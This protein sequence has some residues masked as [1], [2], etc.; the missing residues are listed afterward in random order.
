MNEDG[1]RVTKIDWMAAIPS[2]RLLEAISLSISPRVLLPVLLLLASGVLLVPGRSL[3]DM[4]DMNPVHNGINTPELELPANSINESLLV[5]LYSRRSLSS[6]KLAK[7][8]LWMLIA[9]FCG[10][11]AIRTGGCRFSTGTGPGII[12]SARHSLQSW[13]S[14]LVSTFLCGILLALF[15]V[16][17]RVLCWAGDLTHIGIT[18]AASMFY[19]IVCLVLGIGW[20]LSLAAI[21]IDRCDGAE[22]LSR[23]IC[24]VLSRWQRV[25]VYAAVCCL[26]L[27]LSNS[28]MSWLTG[29]AYSLAS[30]M[31]M[32]SD[33]LTGADTLASLRQSLEFFR[34]L[35]R[36]SLFFCE[37]AIVYVLLRNVEDGVSIQEIDGGKVANT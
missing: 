19:L 10:V 9:G 24:Y 33:H 27:M 8:G 14:I 11:A 23:G 35:F 3:S 2:L 5:N 16:M 29:N 4:R 30:G 20:L 1:I 32:N 13:K 15:W 17:F 21:A 36:L 12:A 37:I 22:A 7:F 26:M 18:A 28:V 31:V 34:E 25:I 6:V